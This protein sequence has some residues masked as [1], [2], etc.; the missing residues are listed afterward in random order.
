V[1]RFLRQSHVI[2][3]VWAGALVTGFFAPAPAPDPTVALQPPSLAHPLGTT[4]VGADLLQTVATAAVRTQGFAVLATVLAVTIALPVG[5]AAAVVDRPALRAI[6]RAV[7]TVIDAVSPLVILAVLLVALPAV[8]PVG[9]AVILGV[10]GWTYLVGNVRRQAGRIWRSRHVLLLREMGYPTGDIVLGH[11]VPDL[12][13]HLAPQL[14]ALATV[15][16]GALGAVEF[17]G[18]GARRQT[19][20]GYLI[21]D[22]LDYAGRSPHYFLAA[23]AATA[24]AVFSLSWGAAQLARSVERTY[25]ND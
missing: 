25:G 2:V 6:E 20:L 1:T 17:L 3:V 7:A 15:Y 14:A 16:V 12:V 19:S 22:S 21:L 23:L 24:V 13:S 4:P 11:L 10:L 18:L 5:L 9:P 8:P